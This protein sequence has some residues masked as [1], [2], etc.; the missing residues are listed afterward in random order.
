[1]DFL[2]CI[3]RGSFNGFVCSWNVGEDEGFGGVELDSGSDFFAVVMRRNG[4]IFC[5]SFGW[6]ENGGKWEKSWN[7]VIFS[8]VIMSYSIEL[9]S[10]Q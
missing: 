6:Q 5:G 9:K 10:A 4:I 8:I 7:L 1:M 2:A 3:L